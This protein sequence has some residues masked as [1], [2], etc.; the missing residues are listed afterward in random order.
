MLIVETP[1]DL[2]EQVGT[3]LGVSDWVEITQE[4]I[5]AFADATG[6]HQWI[7]VDPERAARELPGGKTIAHGYLSLAL[8][9]GLM[10]QLLNIK[11]KSATLNYGSN[12]V[13]FTAPVVVGSR[14]RLRSTLTGAEAL[15][16]KDI[17][18]TFASMME[19]DGSDRP[20][21]VA[22][23]VTQVMG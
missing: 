8:I 18:L 2:L 23:N 9:A 21:L 15:G 5:N 4:K 3:E 16:E 22:E 7:H 10:P 19:V 6:D 14:L 12:K 20:A 1:H 13:R 11:Q 17:R